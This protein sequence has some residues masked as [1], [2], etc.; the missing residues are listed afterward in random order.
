M[1]ESLLVHVRDYCE[2]LTGRSVTCVRGTRADGRVNKSVVVNGTSAL[3]VAADL[4]LTD[5]SAIAIPRKR[6]LARRLQSWRKSVA[7]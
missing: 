5:E 1:N 4:Y 6:D 3:A 7:A 2:R